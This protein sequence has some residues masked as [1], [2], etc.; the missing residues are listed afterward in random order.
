MKSVI[1]SLLLLAAIPAAAQDNFS[2][3]DG[4][5]IKLAGITY[6]LW[7]IDAPETKQAC[8]DGWMAGQAASSYLRSLMEGRKVECEDRGHDRYGRTIGLCNADGRDLGA[9][10]VSAGMAWAF[11]RYSHDYVEPEGT[12]RAANQGIHSH[13]CQPAWEWR[14]ERR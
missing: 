14:A 1:F 9:G 13:G 10:M 4:D 5:T 12:A 7:G 6:R 2:V 11:V 3:T 8:A